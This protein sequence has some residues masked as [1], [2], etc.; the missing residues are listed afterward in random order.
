MH[1]QSREARP[2]FKRQ[3]TDVVIPSPPSTREITT[4][5]SYYYT[6]NNSS[7]VRPACKETVTRMTPRSL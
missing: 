6:T 1:S 3:F 5:G 7:N 4:A 2:Q